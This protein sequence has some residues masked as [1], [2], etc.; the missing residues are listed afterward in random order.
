MAAN[1]PVMV[2]FGAKIDQLVEGVNEIKDHINSINS[3]SDALASGF[4]RLEEAI[5]AA[6]SIEKII[7]FVESM[8]QLG[9]ETERVMA[10]LGLTAA[11]AG[12]LSGI[13]K[14]TGTS[15]QGLALGI[16]RMSL[17][18]QRSTVDALGPQ[19][20]ALKAL[21]INA[22]EFISLPTDQRFLMLADA[23]SKFNPSLNL[24]TALMA[25]GGR[26][27]QQLIPLL[28]L[29]R[30]G[31]LHFQEEV[32][33]AQDGLAAA[34][35][36]M[37]QTHINLA[38]LDLSVQSLGARVFSVLKPAIDLVITSLTRWVQ[39]LDTKT[40]RDF[41]I[42]LIDTL[43]NAIVWLIELFGTLG[44]SIDDVLNRMKRVMTGAALG[45]AMGLFGGPG[46]AAIGAMVGGG[47]VA[48]WDAFMASFETGSKK[49]GSEIDK[50]TQMIRDKMKLLRDAIAGGTAGAAEGAGGKADMGAV[51]FGARRGIETQIERIQQQIA[52]TQGW[53]AQQKALYEQDAATYT[54]TQQ[55]K[56][57]AT[58][59]LTQKEYELESQMLQKIRDLW[60]AHSKEWEAAQTKLLTI[61][62]KNQLDIIKLNT[63]SLTEQTAQWRSFF[64]SIE[65]S[66]NSNLKSLLA[67]QMTWVQFFKAAMGD[68]VMFFIKKVEEM[69]F[70]WIA[71]EA[72]KLTATQTA[73]AAQT[74]AQAAGSTATLPLRI[75]KFTSDI[76]AD[77]AAVFAGI[78]A[79]LSPLMGPAAAGPAAAG[80]ATVMA[81]L[82]AVPK[83]DV[84]T[85][86]VTQTGFAMV[87]QGEKITPAAGSGPFSGASSGGGDHYHFAVS[88]IDSK[89]FMTMLN[90]NTGPLAKALQRAIRDAH[91][92]L[93]AG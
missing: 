1:D 81:Q 83:F 44:E 18:V 42:A 92:K 55:Q 39:S 12:E 14:L 48:M 24:T 76:T 84:G 13:A 73:Q 86:F 50:T 5:I 75:A 51:G 17:N 71:G 80:S 59:S 41:S 43:G 53:A 20:M 58:M 82:A 69:V 8:A 37:A 35:P 11:Q 31:F 62:Q 7:S 27:I 47:V 16:E 38:L 6:F 34:I 66:F 23:V 3:S 40:I 32:R 87:H 54:I 70:N 57:A 26:G 90:N 77:A 46:G 28:E 9:L 21:S 10:Q 74:A 65:N 36:G 2:E 19:A 61:A 4:R 78:F 22:K 25:I 72:A 89:S 79:N 30:V 88:A 93:P 56:I 85:D 15:M 67:G 63:E 68:L 60:P 33:K 91:M 29:G 45:G 49:A 64:G 52:L